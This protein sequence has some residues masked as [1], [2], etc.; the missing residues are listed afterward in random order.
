MLSHRLNDGDV[1]DCILVRVVVN[2]LFEAVV[3]LDG[4]DFL[5]GYPDQLDH[6]D[7]GHGSKTEPGRSRPSQRVDEPHH[8]GRNGSGQTACGHGDAVDAAKDKR[9][10]N[11]VLHENQSTGENNDAK[12]GLQEENKVDAGSLEHGRKGADAWHN[13]V[14]N[15]VQDNHPDERVPDASPLDKDGE[16]EALDKKCNEAIDGKEGSYVGQV[17]A[18]AT[19][20]V[21]AF[22]DGWVEDIDGKNR[23]KGHLVESENGHCENHHDNGSVECLAGLRGR[24]ATHGEHVLLNLD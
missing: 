21:Q 13:E 4:S 12:E 3:D 15:R 2:D 6:S 20:E 7:N 16:D 23:N 8:R 18:Q 1:V 10:R 19:L 17:H 24:A 11:G 22:G 9:R 14:G 5:L